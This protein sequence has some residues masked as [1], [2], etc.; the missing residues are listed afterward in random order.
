MD[1]LQSVE[2]CDASQ[3]EVAPAIYGG[4]AILSMY[5]LILCLTS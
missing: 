5:T 2:W 4:G 1:C 3:C